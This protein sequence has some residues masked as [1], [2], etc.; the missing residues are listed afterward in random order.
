MGGFFHK[1]FYGKIWQNGKKMAKWQK[2]WK[3]D[4]KKW[5]NDKKNGNM[6]KKWQNGKKIE[7]EN[8]FKL[9]IGNIQKTKDNKL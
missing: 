3:N 8:T 2:K 6:K 4:K 7:M 1:V 9:K 5:Q